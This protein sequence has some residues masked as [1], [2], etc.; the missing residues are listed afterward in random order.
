MRLGAA[1]LF[2]ALVSP[3][4]IHAV[5]YRRTR[6]GLRIVR[7]VR[8][9]G[10]EWAPEEAAHRLAGLLESVGGRGG[11]VTVA[12][13]GFGSYHHILTL[14]AAPRDV[15]LPV[16]TREMRRFYP[17]LFREEGEEPMVDF[18]EIDSTGQATAGTTRELLVVGVPRMLVDTFASV[19]TQRGLRLEH[20]TILPLVMQ[21]LYESFVDSPESRAILL[22]I[23]GTP[24]LGFFHG[25]ELRLFSEPS[26]A[27]GR[28]E[29]VLD[30]AVE[31]VQRGEL[32][33]RQQ[34]RGAR[35]T[36][37]QL[38]AE[39][40]DR[41]RGVGEELARRLELPVESFG[42][43]GDAPGS[44]AALGAAL[45]ARSPRGLNL[46]PAAMRPVPSAVRWTRALVV[47]STLVLMAAGGWWA[48][49]GTRA[50]VRAEQDLQ[51]VQ[52]SL[53]ARAEAFE[54]VRSVVRQRQEHAQ[55][56]ALLTALQREH[57][58]LPEL[59]WP[60]QASRRTRVE[61]LKLTRASGSWSGTLKGTAVAPSSAAATGEVEALYRELA[62][63]FSDGAVRLDGLS[64]G[65]PTYAAAADERGPAEVAIS[66]QISF[67]VPSEAE[68]NP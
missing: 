5:E 40:E 45:D 13:T 44:V 16:A 64:Y 59:L 31:Q 68:A 26:V 33:L 21:R 55:R 17:D 62:R 11:R 67:I 25:G 47:A 38:S 51:A 8:E 42:P 28:S 6:A 49:R 39:T 10:G 54:E 14:P 65:A 41:R 30:R 20:W 58:E 4:A 22:L 50:E 18:V 61:E 66:F 23:P 37:L 19:L 24:L 36:R 63:L 56:A 53:A 2:S 3:S 15:L 52:Q 12:I 32:F 46:L 29:S 57:H 27:A 48:W 43:Y 1:R 7:S 35:I 9:I 60:L 34:F